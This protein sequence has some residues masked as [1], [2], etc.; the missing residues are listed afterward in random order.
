MARSQA[1]QPEGRHGAHS[2]AA[3]QASGTHDA[4]RNTAAA[5]SH[6]A[7]GGR[8]GSHSSD[9][10]EARNA[11]NATAPARSAAVVPDVDETAWE[12]W[13]RNYASAGEKE[14]KKNRGKKIAAVIV[15]IV[16]ILAVVA[17]GVY[18]YL[19][20]GEDEADA[21]L[22]AALE[23]V[24]QSD[25][26]IVAL[27]D[28]VNREVNADNVGELEGI[29]ADAKAASATL[30]EALTYAQ[31]AADGRWME[32]SDGKEVA[33]RTVAGIQAR[34]EMIENGI[35]I[36]GADAAAFNAAAELQ[37][38]WLE[39]VDAD[40]Y[41][42]AAAEII[43]QITLNNYDTVVDSAVEQASN[44][45]QDLTEAREH[46]EKAKSYLPE[47]DFST[48]EAFID[49]KEAALSAAIEADRAMLSDNET[50]RNNAVEAYNEADAAAVAAASAIPED[51]S[52][53]ITTA[54]TQLTGTAADAYA[55]ARV[56]AAEADLHVRGYLGTDES[57]ENDVVISDQAAPV[58]EQAAEGA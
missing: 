28:A 20:R 7:S 58:E 49:A 27:D 1:D 18:F 29:I 34:Q 52:S 24:A 57:Q 25:P 12:D 43:S 35:V 21:N 40:A 8:H 31:A 11:S 9:R 2:V 44:G 42:R 10:H 37:Q 22:S 39:I 4:A 55:D 13:A 19:Q 46:L 32:G 5:G 56:R 47:A 48:L 36:L 38:A 23:L 30:D 53:I 26:A 15:T 45:L 50:R 3:R 33:E 54:Y 6:A 16:V 51:I 17:G 14:R 41:S